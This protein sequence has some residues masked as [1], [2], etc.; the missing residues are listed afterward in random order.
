M[1][2][3]LIAAAVLAVAPA[4]AEEQLPCRPNL[5]PCNYAEHFTG[6]VHMR[7]VLKAANP[8][9]EQMEEYTVTIAAGKASCTGSIDGKPVSGAGLLAVERGTSSDEEPGQPWYSITVSCPGRDGTTPNIDNAQIKT[10]ERKDTT[11]LE[12]LAG[13]SQEEHPDAD[14]VNGVSGTVAIEWSLTRPGHAKP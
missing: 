13:K 2:S 10:Y 12:V 11:A 14:P 6:K 7:S 1:R 5:V 8:P 3:M 9:S 4:A